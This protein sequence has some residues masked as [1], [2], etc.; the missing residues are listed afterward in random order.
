MITIAITGGVA[1]GKSAVVSRLVG[2]WGEKAAFFSADAAVHHL[3]TTQAIK[4]KLREV[5]GSAI[6]DGLGEVDRGE[7]RR[8]VFR[9]PALRRTLEEILHPEVFAA[10]QK[11]LEQAIYS[12]RQMFVYEI[13]LLY[14]VE[15][16]QKRDFDI[17]V[18]ASQDTQRLRMRDKR[19]LEPDVIDS[20]IKSQMPID[21]KTLRADI[22]IW[23]DGPESEL[24]EQVFLLSGRLLRPMPASLQYDPSAPSA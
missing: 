1:T 13:P 19:G 10:G 6:F 9:D 4:T 20:L 2:Q 7:L 22:V 17:V 3:L 12:G 16:Q 15:S 14:E 23:N 11:A 24:D 21:Q 5:F 8:I 18:A